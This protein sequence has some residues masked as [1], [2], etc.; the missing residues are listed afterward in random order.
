MEW[1]FYMPITSGICPVSWILCWPFR[2]MHHTTIYHSLHWLSTHFCRLSSTEIDREEPCSWWMYV[3]SCVS[4]QMLTILSQEPM[5]HTETGR[6]ITAQQRTRKELSLSGEGDEKEVE[7]WKEHVRNLE[8][9][10]SGFLQLLIC[11]RCT[12][13]LW[14]DLQEK[15]SHFQTRVIASTNSD[16]PRCGLDWTT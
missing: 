9:V 10:G 4:W 8:L 2:D 6:I 13:L 1:V 5:K 3:R 11:K 15:L 14:K 7:S 12:T 16:T